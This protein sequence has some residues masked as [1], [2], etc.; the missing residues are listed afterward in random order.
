M[1]NIVLGILFLLATTVG[2]EASQNDHEIRVHMEDEGEHHNDD[3]YGTF[4]HTASRSESDHEY[5]VRELGIEEVEAALV[6]DGG[7]GSCAADII[8]GDDPYARE[9]FALVMKQ[10]EADVRIPAVRGGT[11]EKMAQAARLAG[12]LATELGQSNQEL[13]KNINAVNEELQQKTITAKEAEWQKFRSYVAAAGSLAVGVFST[14]WAIYL[15][16]TTQSDPATCSVVC[17]CT[18]NAT[19]GLM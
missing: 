9:Q 13:E 17:N 14:A 8:F 11:V 3:Q 4:Q 2:M 12:R 16:T 15:Q 19:L 7:S 6:P 5:S 1:I 10:E 18:N